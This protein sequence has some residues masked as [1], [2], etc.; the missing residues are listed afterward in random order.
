MILITGG[1]GFIGRHL[2]P[3]LIV[4]GYEMVLLVNKTLP[5]EEWSKK[6][7]I[8]EVDIT[9]KEQVF[10]L[11]G[12]PFK[13]I[14]HLAAYIPK[15]DIPEEF[16]NCLRVNVIGTNNLLEFAK[17]E[18]ITQFINSSTVMVY[19]AT[20]RPKVFKEKNKASPNTYYGMSKLI[21]EI[22]CERYRKKF[23]IKT[24]SLRYAY[25]FGQGMPEHFVFKKFLNR[26]L[27]NEDIEIYGTGRGIR[28]FIYIKDVVRAIISAL[29]KKAVG[30][31]NI[32][33]GKGTS[34][35]DLAKI[36]V[37][38]L[39]SK[40]KIL[41]LDNKKEDKS[42]LVVDISKAQK[43]LGFHPKFLLEDG[44]KDFLIKGDSF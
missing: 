25:I 20:E 17:K 22:L 19:G 15:E 37:K 16:E 26:A 27:R 6:T 4:K 32:G 40:S 13:S 7:K 11:K 28:D 8:I 24:V 31:Y 34:L 38:I 42:Y 2:I 12:Y 35:L 33:T 39:K 23:N 5:P 36:I 30:V 18:G 41:K 9:K 21:G 14:I 44:I 43:I 10:N 3:E 1:T 29:E